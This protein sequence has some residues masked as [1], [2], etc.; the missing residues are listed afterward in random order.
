MTWK[1]SIFKDLHQIPREEHVFP[2]TP[3]CAG[4]GGLESL[5]LAAKVLGNRVVY[6][7]A[8]G[9]FTNLAAFP[10]TPLD[11]SWLYT[12]MGSAPAGA[13]GVRDAL[14]VLIA[15]GRLSGDED[16]KVVVLGGDGSTYDMALS[17]TS[18]AITRRLD[19]Y[20]FCYD[21]EAYGNT[22]VQLSPATPYGARTA[23]SPCALQHPV[24]AAQEKKDIF[25]I[26]RAHTPPYL[27]TVSPRFPL[28]LEEKVAR[29]AAYR[30]PKL[31]LAFA[32]CPTGWLFDPAQTPTVASLAV[33]CGVWPLKEAVDGVVVHTYMPKLHPVE[34]Y[35]KLQGRFRHL[36]EPTVQKEAIA[37]IQ[38]KVN[39]YWER[40]R[41]EHDAA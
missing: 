13:Q 16:V 30:G 19:F 35:L 34:E 14:D 17:S 18:G 28:D 39:A 20:Y 40:V 7:N 41:R 36:F 31:I 23:T 29:A 2:G 37:H 38:A 22:G 6:V 26:W 33:E 11:A 24:G 1:A 9:C 8:A 27:A 32:A 25:E 21:N 4:C 10:F 12:T 15:K 3:L 5:R